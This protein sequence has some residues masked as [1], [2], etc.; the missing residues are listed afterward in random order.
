MTQTEVADGVGCSL[1]TV[2]NAENGR[3][4]LPRT[5]KS[6]CEFL[7]LDTADVVLP[8]EARESV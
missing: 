1:M 7:G 5:G 3:D 6:I 4:V 8:L 2:S